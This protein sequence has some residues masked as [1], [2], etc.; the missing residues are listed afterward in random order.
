MVH[1][2]PSAII[3]QS[4]DG[5]ITLIDI[6]TSIAIAQG[7]SGTLLSTP[8]LEEPIPPKEGC[9]SRA[10]QNTAISSVDIVRHEQY[11]SLIE[12]ALLDIKAHVPGFWCAP[13]QVLPHLPTP[14]KG[15][16][17]PDEVER[18]LGS[19]FREWV[20]GEESKV[21]SLSDFQVM[22]ASLGA[23]EVQ[24]T[25]AGS[26]TQPWI[27]SL[28]APGGATIQ[29][30]STSGSLPAFY[31]AEGQ[32]LNLTI[33][34]ATT[35]DMGETCAYHF[36]VPPL[37]A[38]FLGDCD[39]PELFRSSF[40]DITDKHDLPR[41]FDLVLL[42]PPWPNRSAKRK[43]VYE[44]IGGMPYLKNMLHRMDLDSYIENNALVGIWITN[45]P[46]LR[47]HVLGAGGLFET[48]NVGLIEEWIW[49][50]TTTKGE[51]MFDIDDVM[52]KPYEVLLLGRAAPNSWTTMTHAPKPRKRVIAAVPDVHSR[53]PSLK[54]LLEPYMP[55]PTDYNAL[56]VFARYL[57]AG[58]MSW[59]NEV[60]KYNS[61]VY[62]AK[63]PNTH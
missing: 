3:Y 4:V 38:S 17:G 16:T 33:A 23:P 41:H 48:W 57:V 28:S 54:A 8:P 18:E 55:D 50:K 63:H 24:S 1:A 9:R 30:A 25:A 34:R 22:M 11:R 58:W 39:H 62:W 12:Q 2:Q 35:E 43:G 52:R 26:N 37:S 56:E 6:P 5:E 61:D 21:E 59:G 10:S 40:R 46:A 31:N 51:P 44:Q 27:V 45:K 47:D 53:K 7:R 36:T 32:S 19:R 42:D 14:G 20:A 49:V 60:L 13:R 15:A 29:Q